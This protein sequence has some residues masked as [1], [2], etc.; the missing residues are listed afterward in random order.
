[1]WASMRTGGWPI[2]TCAG[3]AETLAPPNFTPNDRRNVFLLLFL[4]AVFQQ[5]RAEHDHA[6]A[7]DR[8]VGADAAELLAQHLGLV[9]RQAAAA[10]G[11][12]PGRNAPAGLAHRL[13]PGVLLRRQVTAVRRRL[14][15]QALREVGLQPIPDLRP[16]GLGVDAA[17]VGHCFLQPSARHPGRSGAESR[18]PAAEALELLGPGSALQAVRDDGGDHPFCVVSGKPRMRL[19]MMLFWIS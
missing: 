7:A 3:F 18:D 16:E 8:V 6:H 13:A 4:V 19:E 11:L 14:P 17:K 1:M 15:G 2:R 5:G 9:A 10:V 12:G